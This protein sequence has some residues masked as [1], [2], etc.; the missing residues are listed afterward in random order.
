[1]FTGLVQDIGLIESTVRRDGGAELRIATRLEGL[2]IGES[3]A[4]GGA[5]LTVTAFEGNCFR[6]FA[7]A[8]TLSRTGLD[9]ARAGSRVNLERAVRAGDP[10]GG[11]LVTGHVDCRVALL[12]RASS[13]AAE[14]MFFSLPEGPLLLHVAQKGSVCLSGVSLTVNEVLADRFGVMVIPHTLTATTL[15]DARVG[16]LVN[17]ETDVLAK[18]VAR[19]LEGGTTQGGGLSIETLARHGFVR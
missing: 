11:H 8:E 2:A 14:R 12:E 6:A 10:L 3:V 9:A 19:R 16:D 15:S 5:C 7:S 4:V 13:G 17:L 1:M 18:Y